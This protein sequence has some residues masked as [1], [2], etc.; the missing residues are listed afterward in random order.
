MTMKEA[1]VAQPTREVMGVE[2]KVGSE[3]VK[4]AV[5]TV[6]NVIHRERLSAIRLRGQWLIVPEAW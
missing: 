1:K 4:V 2:L 5:G 3:G 6:T